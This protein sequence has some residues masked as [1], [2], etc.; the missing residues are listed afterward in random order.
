MRDAIISALRRRADLRVPVSIVVLAVLYATL[1]ISALSV[2]FGATMFVW[3]RV[4][5]Y[6]AAVVGGLVTFAFA[7]VGLRVIDAIRNGGR[8]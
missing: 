2:A 3:S 6:A 8:E 7:Y 5:V 1:G 4:G